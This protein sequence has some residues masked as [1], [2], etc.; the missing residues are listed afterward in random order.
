M[1]GE[2]NTTTLLAFLDKFQKSGVVPT[3]GLQGATVIGSPTKGV[4]TSSLTLIITQARCGQDDAVYTCKVTVLMAS[5]PSTV[6]IEDKTNL[7]IAGEALSLHTLGCTHAQS[8]SVSVPLSVSLSVSLCVSVSVSPS[9]SLSL[10]L[11]V[12]LSLCLSLS[13]SHLSLFLSLSP[14]SLPPPLSL[15]LTHTKSEKLALR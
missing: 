9:L 1:R 3:S 8:L 13:L 7:T 2:G 14:L 11:S 15:S 10:C 6:T 12:S 4:N 5:P